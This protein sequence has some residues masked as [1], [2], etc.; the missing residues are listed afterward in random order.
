[1]FNSDRSVDV[2]HL[3]G[4]GAG[5]RGLRGCWASA[6]GDK[7]QIKTAGL[8]NLQWRVSEFG[9]VTLVTGFMIQG[10]LRLVPCPRLI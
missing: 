9:I 4:G 2:R 1:V 3:I 6:P 10:F 7:T 8:R 5:K